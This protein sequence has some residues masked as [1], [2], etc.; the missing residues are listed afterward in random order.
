MRNAIKPRLQTLNNGR[1]AFS[2]S[3]VVGFFFDKRAFRA[4][5][6]DNHLQMFSILATFTYYKKGKTFSR[7]TAKR[8]LGDGDEILWSNSDCVNIC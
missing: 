1:G 3:I 7:M 6:T 2:T 4:R 5:F 8:A